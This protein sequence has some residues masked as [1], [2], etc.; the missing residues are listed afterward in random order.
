[1]VRKFAGVTLILGVLMVAGFAIGCQKGADKQ[2]SVEGPFTGDPKTVVAKVGGKEV[3]LAEVDKIVQTWKQNG[4]QIPGATTD[5]DFQKKALDNIVDRQL[6]Y[7]AAQKA[8]MVPPPDQIDQQ[9]Q[10]FQ[11][12][13]GAQDKFQAWLTAQGMTEA[14]AKTEIAT[15]LAVQKYITTSIPDTIKV[16]AGDAKAFYDAHPDVFTTGE[17]IHARHILVKVDPSAAPEQKAASHR[18]AERLLGRVKGGEDFAKVAMDSSDCPSAPKGGDLPE[19]GHGEMV[20][21]FE[22]AAFLLQPGQLSDIVETQFGY[23]II[24]VEGRT[25]SKTVPYDQNVENYAMRQLQSERRN[26]L[27]KKKLAELE[28]GAKIQRKI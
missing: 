27:F 28:A 6:L 22:A 12:R 15:D 4:M 8:N 3:T 11:Q 9:F 1:M 23:H 2:K 26:E 24:K 10:Q 18:K 20:A 25:V 14:Q 5:R 13:F 19:F 7:L 21:P 17:R 16:T